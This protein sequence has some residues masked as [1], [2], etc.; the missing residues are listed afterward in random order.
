MPVD[1]QP[2]NI[3][4][5][6]LYNVDPDWT[7]NEKDEVITLT[8]ELSCA[9]VG[10]GHPLVL[11]AV[12]EDDLGSLLDSFDP[13]EYILFNWCEGLPGLAHSEWLAAKRLEML[14]FTFTGADSET[15]ALAQDKFKV[16]LLLDQAGIPTPAWH[17][18][19]TPDPLEWN[20]F[21]AIVKPMNEH[22]SA[23]ITPDAVVLN[24]AE[25]ASR[26]AFVLRTYKQPALVEEFIDGR[27]FHV[28]VWGNETLTVLPPAE[29]DF[30]FFQNVRDRL[31]TYDAKFIPGSE[32]YEKIQTLLPAP[33]TGDESRALDDACQNA[34][35]AIGC[36]DY[37]RM[38]IRLRDGVFYV[39]DVN[40]NADISS[41]ASMACAAEAAGLSYGQMGSLIVRMAARRHP[42]FGKARK[43]ARR[44]KKESASRVESLD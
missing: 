41:D 2:A 35:R 11:V 44:R 31:C 26:I 4:V 38:D 33:L 10:M 14:G 20:R 3:P 7:Q 12:T 37:A 39:L 36:R 1:I 13:S 42:L 6:L 5:I 8:Q 34:Y 30:S 23:G 16:K 21:P 9:L 24:A 29:M 25:L 19:H 15:L 40:P 28:S 32:H 18:Y 22:C 27:E 17:I 43:I